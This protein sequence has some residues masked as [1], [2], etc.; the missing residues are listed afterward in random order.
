MRTLKKLDCQLFQDTGRFFLCE[1]VKYIKLW[2][3]KVDYYREH[4]LT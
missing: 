2:Y 3:A 1:K 4:F